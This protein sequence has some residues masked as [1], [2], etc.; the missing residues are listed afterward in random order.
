VCLL[1]RQRRRQDE[2]QKCRDAKGSEYLHS[3]SSE[4]GHS[5][6]LGVSAGQ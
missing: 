4:G 3:E 6:L 5:A 1:S 2:S